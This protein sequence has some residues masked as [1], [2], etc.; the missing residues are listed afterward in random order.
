MFTDGLNSFQGLVMYKRR[1]FPF[2]VALLCVGLSSAVA[3][4]DGGL[5]D[6]LIQRLRDSFERD[7]HSRAMINAVS[8]NDIKGLALNRELVAGHESS[9]SHTVKTKGVTNQKSSGRCWLFAGLNVLRP[10]VIEKHGLS[11]FEF[12]QNYSAFWDKMEKSN[13]FLELMIEYREKDP[14][15]R[16]VSSLLEHGIGDGGWWHYA[17]GLIEKYGVA[18]MSVMPETNS[19]S[20]TGMLNKL[21]NRKLRSDA[22]ELR[23]MHAEG[24]TVEQLREAKEAMLAEVYRMLVYNLGEPPVEFE[25]RYKEGD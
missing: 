13:L 14:L 8:N 11:G 7:Q 17:I 5:S 21:L 15:D 22:A 4:N 24:A 19:S 23:T 20:K 3:A 12:S 9:F 6:D 10:A 16:V 2:I 25:F 18:P 1:I